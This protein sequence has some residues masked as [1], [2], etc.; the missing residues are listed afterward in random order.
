[1]IGL[2]REKYKYGMPIKKDE[3]VR[4][5][6]RL[7]Q[8]DECIKEFLDSGHDFWRVNMELLPSK[9]IRVVLS[10]LKWRIKHNPEYNDIQVFMRKNNIYLEKAK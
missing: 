10:S 3:F 5:T 1:V 7:P 4:S 6:R 8:Y 9:D 2:N